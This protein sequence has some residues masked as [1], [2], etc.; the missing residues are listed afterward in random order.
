MD[1]SRD[2]GGEY[3]R[4]NL[5]MGEEGKMEGKIKGKEGEVRIKGWRELLEE[6]WKER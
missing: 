4:M 2:E 3:L 5:W 1:G 6:G